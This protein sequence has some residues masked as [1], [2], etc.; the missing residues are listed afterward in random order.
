M[1]TRRAPAEH[2]KPASAHRPRHLRTL[3][4]HRTARAI[5]LCLVAVV[6]FTGAAAGFTLLRLRGNFTTLPSV[7]DLVA[8]PTP[9][10]TATEAPEPGDAMAGR[11]VNLLVL[12]SDDRSG[13][14][15]ALAGE[16]A[17]GGSDTTLIVHLPADR[18]RVDVVS[19][20]RDSRAQ[21]PACH[22][23]WQPDGKMSRA[24]E[25]KFNA[26]FSYGWKPSGDLALGA[27][28]TI[29]TIQTVTQVPIDA[30]VIVDMAGFAA[31]VDAVGGVRVC[32]PTPL[33]DPRYTRLNLDAGWHDLQGVEA[34][35]YVRA[36]HVKGT[37]GTDTARIQRQQRFIGALLR[38]V[39]SSDVLTNPLA[40]GQFLDAATS[41]LTVSAELGSA[42]EELGLAWGLRHLR[43]D[44]ITFVTVP[45][46]FGSGGYVDWTDDA[47]LLWERLRSDQ[48]LNAQAPAAP[49]G[50]AG[51]PAAT[52]GGSPAA[53]QSP[54]AP[55]TPAA[56]QAPA[57]PQ[58]S[59]E[60][61]FVS[62]TAEDPDEV[63]CGPQP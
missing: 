52:P 26:A 63:L 29:S 22:L 25:D 40:L 36:R 61:D 62:R 46:V 37:D 30:F 18:S 9:G 17:G 15:A 1:S 57:A 16:D 59:P 8:Q 56:P 3:R 23:D 47:D 20:P 41:S 38:K 39:L 44:D 58:P 21:I 53:P 49:A 14:N 48:P 4:S 11:A 45:W 34:L 19:I 31:M 50:P 12:G 13:E 24:H 33:R 28:C 2:S 7:A 54:S 35:Q 32:V 5:A 6:S 42:T 55:Q 10:A 43:A 51:T 60:P 27:A